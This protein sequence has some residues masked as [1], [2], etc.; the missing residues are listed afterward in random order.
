[1]GCRSSAPAFPLG[2]L[3]S[4]QNEELNKKGL[5]FL[6]K[7]IKSIKISIDCTD[8][9]FTYQYEEIKEE[10]KNMQYFNRC[11]LSILL[12]DKK[13]LTLFWS[14]LKRALY[15]DKWSADR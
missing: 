2:I 11:N 6:T 3:I 5:R 7:K 4:N 14:T 9:L 12:S 13:N 15:E 10:L 8:M 1:M